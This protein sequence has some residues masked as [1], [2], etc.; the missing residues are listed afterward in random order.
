MQSLKWVQ[1]V[2]FRFLYLKNNKNS[3]IWRT[4]KKVAPTPSVIFYTVTSPSQWYH[5]VSM[6][7]DIEPLSECQCHF[8]WQ[9]TI[10]PVTISNYLESLKQYKL[11]SHVGK[12]ITTKYR[13]HKTLTFW[14]PGHYWIQ[15]GLHACINALFIP[16]T[17]RYIETDI[18]TKCK[19]NERLL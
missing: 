4:F 12:Q 13:Y 3:E 16:L 9:D 11:I 15:I 17:Y 6:T 7:G 5:E 14:H 18:Y 19:Y 1:S 10:K 8:H 2:I